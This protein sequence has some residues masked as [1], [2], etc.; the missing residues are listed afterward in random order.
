MRD[1]LMLLY[2]RVGALILMGLALILLG[3]GIVAADRVMAAKFSAT[4]SGEVVQLW[5]MGVRRTKSYWVKFDYQP[6]SAA[7]PLQNTQR[8][9]K[10]TYDALTVHEPVTVFYVPG[11][12]SQSRMEPYTVYA[13]NLSLIAVLVGFVI[14]LSSPLAV[15]GGQR[16][17]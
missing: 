7:K 13:E 12:P 8:I 14:M 1:V 5:T 11:Q 4:A 17:S 9:R 6:S 10:T 16:A 2:S 15:R 3:V